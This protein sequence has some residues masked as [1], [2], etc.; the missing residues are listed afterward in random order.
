MTQMTDLAPLE[1]MFE[2]GPPYGELADLLMVRVNSLVARRLSAPGLRRVIGS[3]TTAEAQCARLGVIA[4][5]ELYVLG[6]SVTGRDRGEVLTLRRAIHNSRRV[7]A[8]PASCASLPGVMAWFS[9]R[10]HA[11]LACTALEA[12][13]SHFLAQERAALIEM[14]GSESLRLSL[15]LN[16]PQVLDAVNRYRLSTGEPSARDR[17]SERGILQ[18]LTRALIRVSPLSRLTAVGFATWDGGAP[19]LDDPRLTR[20]QGTSRIRLD[21]ALFANA[22]TGIIDPP[23]GP[24]GAAPE[25]VRR[26]PSLRV[27]DTKIRFQHWADGVRQAHAPQ[28]RAGER[29]YP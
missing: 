29:R 14:L 28:S 26:N 6:G 24:A 22:V 11:D 5:D 25:S 19:A 9:A 13:Y 1:A 27:E 8:L 18:F 20:R 10:Q 17:K 4:C 2:P 21:R 23:T 15:A 12:G 16:S 3:L 7:D